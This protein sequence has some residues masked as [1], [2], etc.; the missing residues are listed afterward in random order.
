MFRTLRSMPTVMGASSEL[1]VMRALRA[2]SPEELAQHR[3]EFVDVVS[4]L[5]ESHAGGGSF[6]LTPENEGEFH[7]FA[8]WLRE[9]GDSL[10]MDWDREWSF[11]VTFEEMAADIPGM[12]EEAAA[13]PRAGSPL[14]QQV[15]ERVEKAGPL[16]I[17]QASCRAQGIHLA[18]EGWSFGAPAWWRVLGSDRTLCFSWQTPDLNDAVAGL[19]G[20]RIEEVLVQG[21]LMAADP[22]LRLSDGRWLEVFSGLVLDPWFLRL[23]SGYFSGAPGLAECV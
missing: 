10:G 22:C 3:A 6:G 1:V 18:G 7:A 13:G 12:R 15:A 9:V 11:D 2:L 23:P 19:R 14:V 16:L 4:R 5:D 8:E 21:R 20:L 17:A